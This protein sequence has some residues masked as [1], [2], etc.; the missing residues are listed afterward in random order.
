MD[1]SVLGTV[2]IVLRNLEGKA[3]I[4]GHIT[5]DVTRISGTAF[6]LIPVTYT[7]DDPPLLTVPLLVLTSAQITIA[8]LHADQVHLPSLSIPKPAAR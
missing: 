7:P 6:G 1:Q 2:A 4:S 8:H 5:L 3:E